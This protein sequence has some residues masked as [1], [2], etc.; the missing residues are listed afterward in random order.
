[1]RVFEKQGWFRLALPEGWEAEGDEEPLTFHHPDGP[2]ALQ[3][4]AQAPRPLKPGERIDVFLMLRAF[5]RGIGVDIDETRAERSSGRGLE[6]ASCEY[7]GDDPEGGR[8]F[9]RV[10]MVTNHDILVFLTYAC[11]EE[12]REAEREAVDGI[13]AALELA[14]PAR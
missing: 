4:T 11:P 14:P 13:V 6:R 10:W 8:A 7:V 12:D 2:G 1:M 5:L 9:W 3:V